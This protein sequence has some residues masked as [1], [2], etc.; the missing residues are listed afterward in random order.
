MK[1]E[2]K[3]LFIIF[4]FIVIFLFFYENFQEPPAPT[5]F[6]KNKTVSNYSTMFFNYDILRYPSD[7]EII[8][9]EQMNGTILLGFATDPWNINFGIT[10][11]NGSFV[12]RNIELANKDKDSKIIL[13]AYGNI[14][15]LVAF[16]KN[17]FILKP[18]ERVSVDITLFSNSTKVGKYSGEIDVIAEKAI[19]NFPPIS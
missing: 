10:P 17:N 14:S 18:Y 2:E 12:T 11:G 7:V 1:K 19:Y 8:P 9:I 15:P 13:K 5:N 16:S 6:V 4:L 3:I